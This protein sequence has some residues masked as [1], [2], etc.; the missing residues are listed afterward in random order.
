MY[1]YIYI[2]QEIAKAAV[3]ATQLAGGSKEDAVKIAGEIAGDRLKDTGSYLNI[4]EPLKG[5]YRIICVPPA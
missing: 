2:N 5:P 4:L 1:I 3:E